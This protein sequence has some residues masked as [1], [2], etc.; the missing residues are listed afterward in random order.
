MMMMAIEVRNLLDIRFARTMLPKLV[1][2][3]RRTLVMSG[4]MTPERTYSNVYQAPP[5]TQQPD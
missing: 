2:K 4:T 3:I 1:Q 5:S